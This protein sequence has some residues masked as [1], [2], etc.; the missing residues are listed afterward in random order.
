MA[1]QGDRLVAFTWCPCRPHQPASQRASGSVRLR[2]SCH[3]GTA[4]AHL[5]LHCRPVVRPS[6]IGRTRKRQDSPTMPRAALSAQCAQAS[7]ERGC[8]SCPR[9]VAEF[10]YLC[11]ARAVACRG[12]FLLADP[13]T[14][15]G[16]AH[17]IR[18]P[19]HR[20]HC[21]ACCLLRCA[22]L[23]QEQQQQSS[24]E[25]R[26]T[27]MVAAATHATPSQRQ[28]N[29]AK[30]SARARRVRSAIGP[31]RRA[32]I[33]AATEVTSLARE[34]EFCVGTSAI[35]AVEIQRATFLGCGG[36]L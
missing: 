14:A 7:H 4:G 25:A 36:A 6:T 17:C 18:P 20:L 3:F 10:N 27:A 9:T 15:V 22:V 29:T 2:R 12:R 13:V 31:F 16:F 30:E 34:R 24:P 1:A 33:C 23:L 35:D 32:V 26:Q 19:V 5:T 28:R 21:K 11:S 8:P